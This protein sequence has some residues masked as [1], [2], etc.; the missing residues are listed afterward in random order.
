[1][2]VCWH[3][4]GLEQLARAKERHETDA[5]GRESLAPALFPVDD[6]DR[7]PALELGAAEGLDRLRGRAT[8]GDDV[9]DEADDLPRPEHALE[10]AAGA[11]ALR[12]LA[13]DQEGEPGLERRGGGQRDRPELGACEERRVRL[14][15]AGLRGDPLPERPQEV[16]AGLEAVLVEVV[17]RAPAGAQNE[18]ALEVRVL[19]DQPGEL[20]VVQRSAAAGRVEHVVSERQQA[21]GLEGALLQ[22]DHRAVREVGAAALAAVR[23][24]PAPGDGADD[25]A[26][27]DERREGLTPGHSRSLPSS[28]P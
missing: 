22:R 21:V 27:D 6:A 1:M 25:R 28:T 8:A 12:L 24:P 26:D 15:L 20:E 4:S 5:E 13:H 11:V 23:A 18:V 14:L 7:R 19:A 16:G 9:L 2:R 10:Q 17:A 3:F